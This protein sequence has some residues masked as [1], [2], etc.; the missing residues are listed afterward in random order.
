LTNKIPFTPPLLTVRVT[1]DSTVIEHTKAASGVNI[2]CGE[3]RRRREGV[4]SGG[5]GRGGREEGEE[6]EEEKGEEEEEGGGRRDREEE[7]GRR[8]KEGERDET[9]HT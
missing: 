7:G 1:R 8:G 2:A 9:T 3:G 5:G 6:E 4:S